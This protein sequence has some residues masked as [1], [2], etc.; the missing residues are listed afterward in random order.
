MK[1]LSLSPYQSRINPNINNQT[2]KSDT[3]NR[4]DVHFGAKPLTDAQTQKIIEKAIKFHKTNILGTDPRDIEEFFAK[5]G[6]SASFQDGSEYA[7][8]FIAY[9]CY[10]ASKIFKQLGFVIPPKLRSIDMEMIE[11]NGKNV[12]G[13]CF[14]RSCDFRPTLFSAPEHFPIRTTVF[15][16]FPRYNPT[17]V[18]NKTMNLCWENMFEIAEHNKNVGWSSS[19]HFLSTFIH[20]FAHNLHYHK[21]YSTFGA[22]DKCDLYEYNPKVNNI[23]KALQ[24]NIGGFRSSVSPVYGLLIKRDISRYGASKL[25]ET[26]AEALTEEILSNIDPITLRLSENPF[27]M[28]K[29]NEILTQIL[30]EIYEGLVNDGKGYI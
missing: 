24:R 9:G 14:F 23:L 8:K 7:R 29:S 16:T 1:V 5:L 20:E 25:P 15:N 12:L 3:K 18:G 11:P 10:Q 4:S 30:H 21:I 17:Q 26:F 28:K 13:A 2:Q 19:G 22:P 6:V 27:P